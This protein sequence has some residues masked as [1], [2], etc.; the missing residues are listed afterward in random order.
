MHDTVPGRP[1]SLFRQASLPNIRLFSPTFPYFDILKHCLQTQQVQR[2][3]EAFDAA[4][5]LVFTLPVGIHISKKNAK[6]AIAK[7]N[8][9]TKSATLHFVL[10]IP[11]YSNYT[12]QEASSY[13]IHINAAATT[14]SAG[15]PSYLLFWRTLDRFGAAARRRARPH[16]T[17]LTKSTQG[18][19]K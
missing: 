11:L 19:M 18:R 2:T 6:I 8:R 4:A 16:A 7:S 15:Q 10:R 3:A 9:R 17:K 1:P 13:M 14:S 5:R 12:K